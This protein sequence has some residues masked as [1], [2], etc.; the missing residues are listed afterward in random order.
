[1]F[2]KIDTLQNDSVKE[3]FSS[4]SGSQRVHSSQSALSVGSD[5]GGVSS[6]SAPSKFPTICSPTLEKAL[7]KFEIRLSR[8]KVDLLQKYCECL[9]TWN[10]RLNL[11]RHTTFDKFV[12]RD[13]TDSIHLAM[14]LQKGERVLDVGTGGGV[15]GLVIAILR[16]DVV[17][18]LCDAT[19]KKAEAL[20]QI[21]DSL[22]LDLNV[23][24]AKAEDL[25]AKRNFHTI[26]IRAVG[27]IRKL[28]L[29][30]TP[31][32]HSL[33]RILMV[34]G[35]NWLA[36]RGEARHY[37]MFNS[38]ALRKLDEY[39]NPGADYHSVILQLCQKTRIDEMDRHAKER[40][41]GK[42]YTCLTESLVVE[43]QSRAF[44]NKI[45]RAR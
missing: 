14:Q 10:E 4:N 11:T 22:G 36:E 31:V 34:K 21:V 35:P 20:G 44:S 24:Y 9:W 33:D 43:K 6:P 23:W 15:P 5:L 1:M 17:I 41:D 38:V 8:K 12:S 40:T 18:E 3:F 42:P 26:T 32:W 45:E 30:F 16:P 25:L 39:D 19:G 7:E 2:P 13:L 29:M 28:L 27:K 37:N